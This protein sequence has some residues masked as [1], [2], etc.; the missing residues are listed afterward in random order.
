MNKIALLPN[1]KK[2]TDLVLTKQV[3][4]VLKRFCEKIYL[5]QGMADALLGDG[6]LPYVEDCLPSDAELLLVIGGDGSLLHAAVAAMKADVPLLGINMGRLGYLAS[7]EPSE[8]DDLVQLADGE[9][10]EKSRMTLEVLHKKADGSLCSVGCVL[11]EVVVD[12]AGHLTELR[13][14]DKERFL[15]YRAGGLIVSTPTGSTAYSLSAGG[16]IIDEFMDAI[17]VTPICSRSFFSRSILF[18]E[19]SV[20][21]VEHV[22][23][24]VDS[25]RISM[26]GRAEFPLLPGEEVI[27]RR[28]SKDARFLLLK[29]RD[30]LEVL[31][32]KMNT[33]HF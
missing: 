32:T 7:V 12:G 31:C 30:L 18:R 8:I 29:S 20:L 25:L 10:I 21:R 1:V 6:V 17:C 22:G 11:N 23:E 19:D 9:Y 4:A 3:L 5:P 14:H 33:Q 16:P 15:D 27:V 2:D 24:R 26:D 13:L 28:A